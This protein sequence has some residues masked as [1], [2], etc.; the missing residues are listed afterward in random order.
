MSKKG[1]AVFI[2]G[3][4]IGL[5]IS[6]V[7]AVMVDKTGQPQFCTSC[8]EMKPMG[9]S[10]KFSVHGGNNPVGFAAHHCTDCHLPHD[11]LIGY[12]WHKGLSGMRDGLA[13]AGIIKKVDFSK[14]FWRMSEYTYD[15][16]CLKCHEGIKDI[17]ENPGL[18]E[19]IKMIHKKYYWEAKANGEEV[20]CVTCHNDYTHAN[21]AHPNLLERLNPNQYPSESK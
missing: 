15:S 14:N 3:A 16:G 20:S 9:E 4:I 8:H 11:S 10:F 13:H 1:W 6:Y 7:A 12:L 2:G 5:G 18:S 19:N 21:F 17:D